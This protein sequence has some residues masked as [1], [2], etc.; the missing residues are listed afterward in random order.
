MGYIFV[1]RVIAA[2]DHPDE[3]RAPAL[4]VSRCYMAT[5]IQENGVDENIY[6]YAL[7]CKFLMRLYILGEKLYS[8]TWFYAQESSVVGAA[9]LCPVRPRQ[10]TPA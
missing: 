4:S 2:A 5:D 3:R 1:C 6:L 8:S 7:V 10:T 9:R